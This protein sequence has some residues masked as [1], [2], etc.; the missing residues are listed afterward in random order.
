MKT[1]IAAIALLGLSV[2]GATSGETIVRKTEPGVDKS[3]TIPCGKRDMLVKRLA[4]R[5]DQHL[6][7]RAIGFKGE[8]MVELYIS[9]SGAWTIAVTPASQPDVMC[10]MDDGVNWLDARKV[11]PKGPAA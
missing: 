11:G 10:I 1:A 4:E 3:D 8:R 5:L 9:E 6:A 2:T 7:G